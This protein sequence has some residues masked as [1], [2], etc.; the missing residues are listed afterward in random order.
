LATPEPDDATVFEASAEVSPPA[1]PDSLATL[2]PVE[3]APGSGI[4]DLVVREA[5]SEPVAPPPPA[6]DVGGF[7]PAAT[8]RTAPPQS[9][10]EA[11]TDDIDEEIREVFIEEVQEEIANLEALLPAW[12]ADPTALDQL[13]PIRRVFHTLKGSGRLVGAL[14]L[15]EFS[16]K[17]ENMLNRVLDQTIPPAPAALALVEHAYGTLPG[18]LAALR[19]EGPTPAGVEAIKGVADRI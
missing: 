13:K 12:K 17:V 4:K 1:E 15:G 10:F 3:L 11:T 18:L 8:E 9:G 19:G 5:A 6:R 7:R 16:W 2:S 14:T